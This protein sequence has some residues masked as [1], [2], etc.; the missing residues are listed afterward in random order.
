MLFFF[1]DVQIAHRVL[2]PEAVSFAATSV[3]E[4]VSYNER[5]ATVLMMYLMTVLAEVCTTFYD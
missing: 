5:E 3:L 1:T 4:G 2:V